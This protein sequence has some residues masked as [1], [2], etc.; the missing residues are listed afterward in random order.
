MVRFEGIEGTAG[1]SSEKSIDVITTKAA[2]TAE[3]STIVYEN[4]EKIAHE[5]M[6]VKPAQRL[7]FYY[8]L[9]V[10]IILIP[11]VLFI[12]ASFW[13]KKSKNTSTSSS[14]I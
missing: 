14:P 10:A 5:Q 13:M 9:M 6:Q 12:A 11:A 2:R 3:F 1:T 4:L 7:E 8:E